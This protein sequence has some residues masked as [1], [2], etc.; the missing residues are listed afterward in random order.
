LR[1]L[2]SI[3]DE[4]GW[5][6]DSELY[7]AWQEGRT[8]FPIVDA[9]AR[10][11]L[12]TGGWQDL[13]FRVRAIYASFLSNLLG[14]DWRYGALHFMRHLIDGDCPIDHYQWAMQ[15]GV[16]HCLDKSWTRIY[17]PE[18]SA[19]DRCDTQGTFIK[20]WLPELAHLKPDQLGKP[21]ATMGYCQPI[22][23]YKTA[24][25]RR[26]QQLERQRN[27]FRQEDNVQPYLADLPCDLSPF[28]SE[29]FSDHVR[30]AQQQNSNLFPPSLDVHALSPKQ[31]KALRTWLVAHVEIQP[32][33]VRR[34]NVKPSPD[35][36]QL[37]LFSL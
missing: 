14:M 32:Q 18:Q 4:E 36:Q 26:V 25:Q 3:F 1:S 6:F 10:C 21:P 5:A 31:I 24:R 35:F 17:N 23:D 9:A 27:V 13:N 16:T 20:R 34:R 15:A 22:L 2:Y 8:G 7:L 37:S 12:A 33:Q 11:L 29:E 30:W 19:V 28:C